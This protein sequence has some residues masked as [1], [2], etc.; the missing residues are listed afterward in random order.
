M[1]WTQIY[2]LRRYFYSNF[3]Y[4][5]LA[6]LCDVIAPKNEAQLHTNTINTDSKK[7]RRDGE[8]I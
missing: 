4:L 3:P 6:R 5:C 2:P 8:E 1:I 7:N